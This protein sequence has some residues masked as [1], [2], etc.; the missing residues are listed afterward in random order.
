MSIVAQDL[1]LLEDLMRAE[2]ETLENLSALEEKLRRSAI[3]RDW[4][5]LDI[6]LHKLKLMSEKVSKTEQVRAVVYRK[7]TT[8]CQS[9]PEEGFQDILARIPPEERGNLNAMHNRLRA[10]VEKVKC[11]TGGIDT[12]I[13]STA[14]TMD[15]ILEEIFPGRRNKIYTRTGETLGSSQP[16]MVSHT[17]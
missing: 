13:R 5:S 1:R 17:L 6:T 2:A 10:A 15:Q 16:M 11:L 7:I 4:S 3:R 9:G 14:G 8:S 12:Y